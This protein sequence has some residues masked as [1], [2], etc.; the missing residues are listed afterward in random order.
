MLQK[1]SVHT[2]GKVC[3]TIPI[4]IEVTRFMKNNLKE[5]RQPMLF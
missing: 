1:L 3:I 4:V 5:F 2:A